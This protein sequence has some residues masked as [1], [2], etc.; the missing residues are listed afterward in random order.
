MSAVNPKPAE[1][2]R[3]SL[4]EPSARNPCLPPLMRTNRDHTYRLP[5]SLR[6]PWRVEMR[7]GLYRVAFKT[8]LGE[9]TG[10]AY[11]HGGKLHGGDTGQFYVGDYQAEGGQFRANVISMRHSQYPGMRSVFGIDTAHITLVGTFQGDNGHFEGTAREAPGVSF[12]ASLHR[13]AD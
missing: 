1:L 10:V 5:P 6:L 7:D 3:I 11:L 2:A 8:Q 12:T 9:G 4:R 13:I